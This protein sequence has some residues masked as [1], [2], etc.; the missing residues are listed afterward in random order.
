M[1]RV[2]STFAWDTQQQRATVTVYVGDDA[3]AVTS[4]RNALVA[5]A[6]PNWTVSVIAATRVR[7]ALFL[8]IRVDADRILDDVVAQVRGALTDPDT[9]L[10]GSRRTGIGES[11]YFSQLSEACLAVPGV[12]AVT[13]AL[14]LL[15]RPDPITNFRF[16][17]LYLGLPPR[18]NASLGEFVSMEPE[19]AFIFTEVITGV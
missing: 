12:D 11:I 1:T 7:M 17:G 15:D 13:F 18:I 16:F 3:T 10:F 2:R 5:S 9:G 4:A 14:F 6:D 8:A 19:L